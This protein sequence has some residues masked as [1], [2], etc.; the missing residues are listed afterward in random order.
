MKLS[1]GLKFKGRL[2]HTYTPLDEDLGKSYIKI[3][4]RFIFKWTGQYAK[5]VFGKV[6]NITMV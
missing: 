3:R 5:S 2:K 6:L 4:D 1:D